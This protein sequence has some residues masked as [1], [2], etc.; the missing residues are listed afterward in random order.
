MLI[1]L[2]SIRDIKENILDEGFL[3]QILEEKLNS[4]AEEF[5]LQFLGIGELGQEPDFVFYRKWIEEKKHAGMGFLEKNLHCRQDNRFLME[6]GKSAFLFASSYYLGDTFSRLPKNQIAQYARSKDYHKVLKK[7]LT[8]FSSLAKSHGLI[9]EQTVARVFVDSAPVLERSLAARY[10]SG[11]IGKNTLFILPKSGSFYF[12]SAI[13]LDVALK[14]S[15]IRKPI[16]PLT[17]TP[18]G[19]CGSCKRCQ[20]FCPTGALDQAYSLDARKCIA[21]Y[22]IEHRGL[23]PLRFWHYLKHYFFGCDICQLVCPYNRNLELDDELRKLEVIKPG[24]LNL[25]EVALMDQNYYQMKFGG[26]PLTRAKIQGLKR[27]AF[28]CSVVNRSPKAV[29]NE[30]REHFYQSNDPSLIGTAD[31]YLE[32]E[33]KI[34]GESCET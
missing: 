17:R 12:L 22:T 25:K 16:D 9:P 29:I 5:K 7:K 8:T 2:W 21:Y 3:K 20:V 33:K 31:Q 11:F 1:G 10:S 28:I 23:I 6:N 19:G 14:P 4:L 26:T 30:I 27:N 18:N 13:A 34:I 24:E 32:F 15:D